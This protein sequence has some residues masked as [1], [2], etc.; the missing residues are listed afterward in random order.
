MIFKHI[1]YSV[2]FSCIS[3]TASTEDSLFAINSKSDKLYLGI[4]NQIYLS[5]KYQED[6]SYFFTTNNGILFKDE[7]Q[8]TIIPRKKPDAYIYVYK[9]LGNDTIE[10]FKKRFFVS[11]VPK[12]CVI[13]NDKIIKSDIVL[14][15]DSLV[16]NPDLSIHF[17]DDIV[18]GDSWI[19][20]KRIS[21]GIANGG[22]YKSFE[23]EGNILS[24]EMLE[25]IKTIKPRQKIYLK[26]S[27]ESSSKVIKNLPVYSLYIF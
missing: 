26:V 24:D 12:P 10:I 8:L 11:Y 23:A 15:K 25:F 5:K 9:A 2:L 6:T 19:N 4:D 13:L 7:G 27:I 1:I 3:L 16:K 18:G 17:S 22:I 21:I 14:L 20:I